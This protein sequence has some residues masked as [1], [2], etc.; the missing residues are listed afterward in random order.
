MSSANLPQESKHL[1]AIVIS[2][3]LISFAGFIGYSNTFDATFHF[4]D[5][6]TIWANPIIKDIGNIGHIIVNHPGRALGYISF[7]LNY[8]FGK[9]DVFQ[10]HVTNLVIH[11]LCG[12]FVFFLLS[13][14]SR[15]PY[16]KAD[17]T[18][19]SPF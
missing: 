2:L 18:F 1:K 17:K 12:F 4:D 14:F 11:I 3:L 16:G 6:S 15:T 19:Q 10:Y 7:T 13:L 5:E 9:L 8:H